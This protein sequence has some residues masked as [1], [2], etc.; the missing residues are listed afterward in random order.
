MALGDP[1]CLGGWPLIKINSLHNNIVIVIV[2]HILTNE[3]HR[4]N[5]D[6]NIITFTNESF[7]DSGKSIQIQYETC[8]G[9]K[10]NEALNYEFY[11]DEN[12]VYYILESS[13]IDMC[14]NYESYRLYVIEKLTDKLHLNCYSLTIYGKQSQIMKM[15][16]GNSDYMVNYAK[17]MVTYIE[18]AGDLPSMRQERCKSFGRS[19]TKQEEK[20][21]TEGNI[22]ISYGKHSSLLDQI[23][24]S[25][26]LN[27]SEIESY[28]M[29]QFDI[30]D[31][32]LTIDNN[33]EEQEFEDNDQLY[34]E[35][36]EILKTESDDLSQIKN[37]AIMY[38]NRNMRFLSK[39]SFTESNEI[40]ISQK[41][42][43]DNDTITES[44]LKE[45]IKIQNTNFFHSDEIKIVDSEASKLIDL[46]KT[47]TKLEKISN[48]AVV[49]P[50]KSN[51]LNSAIGMS[52]ITLDTIS[53]KDFQS[54]DD[55]LN[56][57]T[58]SNKCEKQLNEHLYRVWNETESFEVIGNYQTETSEES[59]NNQK[60]ISNELINSIENN[61][62]DNLVQ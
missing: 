35:V 59:K 18:L 61:P 9:T 46:K 32:L 1:P 26:E 25:A 51:L 39:D 62:I 40:M 47:E 3:K 48:G 53:K 42:D 22:K 4:K 36:D 57:S 34:D 21:K 60:I 19:K 38:D 28:K 58:N 24:E 50:N 27:S 54:L 37:E 5:W 20:L 10:I 43:L 15:Y 17:G 45:L 29:D 7:E 56:Q 8:V 2:A 16:K 55:E 11:Q 31:T 44:P 49:S 41:S 14:L 33:D 52:T 23:N 12:D 30:K 13:K 6:M